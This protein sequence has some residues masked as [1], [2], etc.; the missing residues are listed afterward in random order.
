MGRELRGPFSVVVSSKL[1]HQGSAYGSQRPLRALPSHR[2]CLIL[3]HLSHFSKNPFSSPILFSFPRTRFPPVFSFSFLCPYARCDHSWHQVTWVMAEEPG[4]SLETVPPPSGTASML[5]SVLLP[6]VLIWL[7]FLV[8]LP[9]VG[10]TP[11]PA[12]CASPR[13]ATHL[14]AQARGVEGSRRALK[15][16]TSCLSPLFLVASVF[17]ILTVSI[18]SLL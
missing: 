11:V 12:L 3:C 15:E 8:H 1:S 5:L 16:R 14:L 9:H 13:L 7:V 6:R 2:S 18:F 17:D 4:R 10:A